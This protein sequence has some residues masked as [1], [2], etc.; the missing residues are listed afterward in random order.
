VELPAAT[1]D[2]AARV[3]RGDCKLVVAEWVAAVAVEE[4]SAAA[5]I[6]ARPGHTD[7]V[8]VVC[9]TEAAALPSVKLA[10]YCSC[11]RAPCPDDDEICSSP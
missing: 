9:V 7:V 10:S 5:S 2:E 8:E 11:N 1:R 3:E 6:A 4:I